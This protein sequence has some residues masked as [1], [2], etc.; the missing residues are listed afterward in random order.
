M[1]NKIVTPMHYWIFFDETVNYRTLKLIFESC[2]FVDTGS[3]VCL[4]SVESLNISWLSDV[5]D[6][7]SLGRFMRHISFPYLTT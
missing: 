6:H 5:F 4:E 7:T 2:D 3:G 1:G